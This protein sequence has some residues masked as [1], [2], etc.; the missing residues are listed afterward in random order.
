MMKVRA[1]S[2]LAFHVQQSKKRGLA[3][4][5]GFIRLHMVEQAALFLRR[6]VCAQY[7]QLG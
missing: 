7:V 2:K 5:T 1:F 3:C 6:D 4:K